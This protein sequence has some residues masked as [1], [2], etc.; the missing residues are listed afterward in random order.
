MTAVA[1]A[2][3]QGAHSGV[4]RTG[5]CPSRQIRAPTLGTFPITKRELSLAG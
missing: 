5:P 4:D 2:A 3:A 1:E